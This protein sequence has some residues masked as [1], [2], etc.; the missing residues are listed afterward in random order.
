MII[1]LFEIGSIVCAAAP[2]SHAFI[3]GRALAGI[4]GGGS[5]VGAQVIIRSLVPLAKV[6][7]YTGAIG[8]AF[9]IA[10]VLGPT[11]G[12]VFVTDV[13][14]RWCFWINLP[15]GGLA[16]VGLILVLPSTP[17]PSKLEGTFFEK[18]KQFDPVGNAVLA[19]GLILFLLAIQWGGSVYPWNSARVIGCL[20]AGIVLIIAFMAV[21]Y[22]VQEN[23]TVPPRILKQRSIA[24]CTIV[25]LCNG[26]A[27][28]IISFYL[29]I[30]FQAIEGLSAAQA[31]VR[32]LP[33]FLSTVVFVIVSGFAVSK[34]G[35][36]TPFLIA[37]CAVSI[38]ATGLLT[39]L[40]S[41]TTTGEWIGYQVSRK[42]AHAE[43]GA[44]DRSAADPRRCR[45]WSCFD[46]MQ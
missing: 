6:P 43:P 13:S 35:Y 17:A 28:I 40:G 21:Q 10:S 34:L 37:G 25:S 32:L 1:A 9:G 11:L 8:A 19:P 7:A 38:V 41:D 42:C 26:A 39:T 22:W 30:W 5:Q 15:I 12:G 44:A 36:Y 23:G 20:V 31:G 4:G 3:V 14:W 18:V 46:T 2:S 45:Q 24:A 27:L 29:P 33:F 16:L